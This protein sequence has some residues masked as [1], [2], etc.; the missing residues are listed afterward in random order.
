MSV[1]AELWSFWLAF[2]CM[3]IFCAPPPPPPPHSF[4]LPPRLLQGFRVHHNCYVPATMIME[5]KLD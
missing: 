5:P 2:F 1:A 3:Q 4:W